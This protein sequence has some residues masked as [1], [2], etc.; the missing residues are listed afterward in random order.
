MAITGIILLVVA[1]FFGLQARVTRDTQARNE[2]NVRTR[3]ALEAIVQDV[4][5]AGAR[6]VVDAAGRAVFRRH[7]DCDAADACLVVLESEGR[8]EGLRVEYISSLFLTGLVPTGPD[9]DVPPNACR[10]I[11]YTLQDRTLYRSDVQCDAVDVA[12]NFATELAADITGITAGFACGPDGDGTLVATPATCFGAAD[13]F[14][15]E[16]QLTLSAVSPRPQGFDLSLASATTTPNLR[17]ALRFG[18]G[19]P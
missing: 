16:V 8:I 9:P 19:T 3:A 18:E 17:S 5:M 4:K 2:L 15:R 10:R 12:P 11:Q 6:A 13:G 7:L 14:V 1:A